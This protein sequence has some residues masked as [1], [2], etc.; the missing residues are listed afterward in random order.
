MDEL[1]C[2]VV[3]GSRLVDTTEPPQQ[4]CSGRVQVVV[5]VELEAVD[6]LE[7]SLDVTRFGDCRGPVEL[8][9]GDPVRRASSPYRRAS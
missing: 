8:D 6:E 3:L 2:A 7:R 5:A 1:E 4:L 9:D